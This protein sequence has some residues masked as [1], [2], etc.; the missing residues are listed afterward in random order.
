[1]SLLRFT[2]ANICFLILLTP[3]VAQ[4]AATDAPAPSAEATS[5]PS[6][7][8]DE[9]ASNSE[10]EPPTQPPTEEGDTSSDPAPEQESSPEQASPEQATSNAGR[11]DMD[12]ATRLKLSA[13]D[14]RQLGRV[15]DLLSRAIDKGLNDGDREFAEQMLSA[16]LMERG[17]ALSQMLLTQRLPDPKQDPRWLQIRDLA[18][19]DLSRVVELTPREAD[20]WLLIGRLN[21]LPEGDEAKATEAYTKIIEAAENEDAGDGEIEP[22]VL[23]EAL[24]RRSARQ[25]EN[26]AKLAD[27]TAAIEAQPKKIEYR[28]FR[29][30]HHFAVEN[31]EAALVDVDAALKIEPESYA[32]H[33]LRALVLLALDRNED[34]LASFD[35]ATELAPDA[36][37]PYLRRS[38]MYGNLGNLEQAI[39]QATK[40]ID[41][42]EESPLGYLMRSD[43]Y[44]RNEQPEKS[45]ADVE[46][47]L[48][49]KPGLVQGFLLKAR[50]YDSLGRTDEAMEQLEQLAAGLPPQVEINLQIAMYALQLEM[51][52]RAIESLDRAL[53]IEPDNALV[54]RFRG[55][56][57]LNISQHEQA[58]ASYERALE[59]EPE[60]AGILNN[61]AWTLA[62]SPNDDVR[63]GKR[64]LELATQAGEL[65]SYEQAHILSTIAA[66]YAETGD[67]E[68]AKEWSKKAVELAASGEEQDEDDGEQINKEY[69]SYQQGKPWRESQHL[70]SGEREDGEPAEPAYDVE[71]DRPSEST[72]AP[73]RTIDF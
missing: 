12:E 37:T 16:S 66:A 30:R 35:R 18:M 59:L 43:L 29:A 56:A 45:L 14:G 60:D 8:A 36:I 41:L 7:E 24:V 19:A 47:A 22:K 39:A 31:Y 6:G 51:P 73:G 44:L 32:T 61:L 1:M 11:E 38:E 3:C 46:K 2:C 58:V 9:P 49:L 57:H 71:F 26:D 52:R 50:A 69:S 21:E 33:E 28:L 72:P 4:Q 64:A 48:E 62:T 17:D 15:I 20:A 13:Q 40:A 63:D 23:A 67:F 68:S 27:L 53:A 10:N 5:P 25:E 34:A 65:T 70:D 54:L 55:D 42:N